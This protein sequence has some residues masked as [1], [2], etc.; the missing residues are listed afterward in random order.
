MRLALSVWL[1]RQDADPVYPVC[2]TGGCF[3]LGEGLCKRELFFSK[4]GL[5]RQTAALVVPYVLIAAGLMAYNALRFGSPS[6]LV[7]PIA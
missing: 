1:S 5:G 3:V 4:K 2:S 6:I 7:R